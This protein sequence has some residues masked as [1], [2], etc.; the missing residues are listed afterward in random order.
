MTARLALRSAGLLAVGAVVA[1]SLS[2]G[3]CLFRACTGLACPGCGMTRAAGRLVGGDV[4]GSLV[5]HPLLLPLLAVA[6]IWGVEWAVRR[7]TGGRPVVGPR[8][9]IALAVAIPVV[10]LLRLGLGLLPPV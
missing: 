1:G 5:M 9:G 4:A 6:G 10:W 8:L 7:R 3:L 2:D